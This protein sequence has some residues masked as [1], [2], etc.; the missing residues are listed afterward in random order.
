MYTYS[1]RYRELYEHYFSNDTFLEMLYDVGQILKRR[2]I[3]HLAGNVNG[4]NVLDLGCGV[5]DSAY[6]LAKNGRV[7]TCIDI[8]FNSLRIAK[9]YLTDDNL[10]ANFLVGDAQYLPFRESCFD[11]IVCTGVLEHL[12]NDDICVS[13]MKRVLRHLGLVIITVPHKLFKPAEAWHHLRHYDAIDIHKLLRCHGFNIDT[14][15]F[16]G[17]FVNFVWIKIIRNVLILFYRL[18]G[19]LIYGKPYPWYKSKSYRQCILRLLVKFFVIDD[20]LA[21]GFS[22]HGMKPIELLV[23]ATK[24][25]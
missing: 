22:G 3:L 14:L 21:K 2:R 13:E 8:S 19:R 12:P 25:E 5:G 4:K 10:E 7:V 6:V 20:W 16:S 9:G 11:V 24:A 1:Q 15:F 23:K 18:T 17:R